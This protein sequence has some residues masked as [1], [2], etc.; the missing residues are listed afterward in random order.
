[1]GSLV[2]RLGNAPLF[3]Q[4][5]Y[6]GPADTLWRLSGI[7]SIDLSGPV[8]V[9]ADVS[10]TARDP[11][12][13]G[14]LKTDNLRLE[15]PTSGTVLTAMKAVGRFGGSKLVID[16]FT[17]KAGE[18]T[19]NGRATFDLA[20]AH[21]FG[22]D[23]AADGKFAEVIRRDDIG[24]TITGPVSIKSDGGS[25][26]ISGNVKL[27][28]SAF[29]L[30]RASAAAA[31][32]R[33]RVREIN[34]PPDAAEVERAPMVWALDIKANAPNRLLV[35]G[36]GLD[37]EWRADL[38]IGGTLD[39]PA[40]LGR[41]DLVRGG[42]EFAGKRFD[43]ARGVIRF[44][45]ASPPD[46]VLDIEANAAIQGLS[47]T[48]RV[49]GTGQHPDIAFTSTPALPQEELLSRLLF[50]T[51]ITNLS[52]PEALQLAAAVNGLR[53]GG[54]IDPINA[55]RK[56]IGLDRLRILPADATTRQG[57]AIAAG[58][59]IT[60]RTYVEVIS[61]GAGYSATRVEFQITRWLS[62]LSTISTIG[63]QSATVR[64]SK[65]Y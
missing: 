10:G 60:R 36:L 45:G 5:R 15:S 30:G 16:S 7:E 49:T 46:P 56:A 44:Q 38:N 61:D 18:G 62:L 64:I 50:G 59:Y 33:L 54:G 57:T 51:S 41:A 43:L 8:A 58:K 24:A 34:Q 19:L 39:S 23:I 2:T 25:S 65:D 6:N 20:A 37:S 42:Y 35:T 63:R 31:V 28:R 26:T 29:R 4:L 27:D 40:I 11:Q 9:G 13:R 53:G 12:I 55:I 3:A 1:G 17:A 14:S 22:M 47:A 48:I 21:G 32:P 52:A